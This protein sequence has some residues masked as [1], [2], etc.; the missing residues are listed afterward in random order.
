MCWWIVS[1]DSPE[2]KQVD[3]DLE[4]GDTNAHV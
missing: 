3:P 1:G 2:E 4:R